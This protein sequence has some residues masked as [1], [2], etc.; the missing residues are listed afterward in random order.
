ML[1]TCTDVGCIFTISWILHIPKNLSF[2]Q[3]GKSNHRIQRRS[4]LVAYIGEKLRL[5]SAR[6]IRSVSLLLEGL[7]GLNALRHVADAANELR[8]IGH[9]MKRARK[10]NLH[11]D[12][13]AI[14]SLR[15][16]SCQRIALRLRGS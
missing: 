3:V 2:D 9:W 1:S 10:A 13:C 8:P 16:I 7:L 4:Q 5:G 11:P 14:A 15:P 6:A 12:I